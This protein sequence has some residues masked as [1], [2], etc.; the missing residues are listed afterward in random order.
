M[1]GRAPPYHINPLG[2]VPRVLPCP[3]THVHQLF[4]SGRYI[5]DLMELFFG[6]AEQQ[7]D[8]RTWLRLWYLDHTGLDLE[9]AADERWKP[10]LS[11]SVRRD[12]DV[13][14]STWRF[15]P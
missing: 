3:Y 7:E 14:A 8:Q 6:S 12:P 13:E 11:I 10:W 4:H 15:R 5:D 2:A 1:E 9:W